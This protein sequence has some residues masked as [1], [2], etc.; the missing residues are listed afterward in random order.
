MKGLFS[1][2][3]ILNISKPEVRLINFFLWRLWL[4]WKQTFCPSNLG[5]TKGDFLTKI[6]KWIQNLEKSLKANYL[7][8]SWMS[9]PNK[10]QVFVSRTFIPCKMNEWRNLDIYLIFYPDKI[11]IR[12]SWFNPKSWRLSLPNFPSNVPPLP[13]PDN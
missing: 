5:F 3:R 13:Y 11:L 8:W 4:E 12:R 2:E 7:L 6:R 9:I 1:N 10:R